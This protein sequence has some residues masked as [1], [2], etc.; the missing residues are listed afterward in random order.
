MVA[1]LDAWSGIL[2]LWPAIY[3]YYYIPRVYFMQLASETVLQ[4]IVLAAR[5]FAAY[6]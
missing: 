3:L 5:L 2:I 6:L 1:W 4:R